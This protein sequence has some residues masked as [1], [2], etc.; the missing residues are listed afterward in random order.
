M[1]RGNKTFSLLITKRINGE[2]E[3]TFS[4]LVLYN[5]SKMD[6]DIIGHLLA[7]S[8]GLVGDKITPSPHQDV[9]LCAAKYPKTYF[10]S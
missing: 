4:S 7:L 10:Y 1:F 2:T 9:S 6:K 3:E 5:G 8:L